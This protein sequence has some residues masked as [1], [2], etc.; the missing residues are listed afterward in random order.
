MVRMLRDDEVI[1]KIME[2][3]AVLGMT[4]RDGDVYNMGRIKGLE[5]AIKEVQS[6]Y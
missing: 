6:C 3:I 4:Q 5:D 2:R 1:Q